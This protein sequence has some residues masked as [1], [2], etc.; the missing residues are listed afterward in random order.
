LL[1]GGIGE[2]MGTGNTGIQRLMGTVRQQPIQVQ[3]IWIPMGLSDFQRT[4]LM[5]PSISIA[6]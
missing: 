5:Q 6:T 4:G 3:Q 1:D 2:N